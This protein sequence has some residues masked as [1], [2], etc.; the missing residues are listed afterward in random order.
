MKKKIRAA[1]IL[2]AFSCS[3]FAQQ[4]ADT[5]IYDVKVSEFAIDGVDRTGEVTRAEYVFDYEGGSEELY[6]YG[7]NGVLL[8]HLTLDDYTI[9][10]QEYDYE[11][12]HFASVTAEKLLIPVGE[13]LKV[14]AEYDWSKDGYVYWDIYNTQTD[15][16]RIEIEFWNASMAV[17]DNDY[18]YDGYDDY[19]DDYDYDKTDSEIVE[20]LR[21]KVDGVDRTD[22]VKSAEY[23]YSYSSEIEELYLYDGDGVLIERISI[24]DYELENSNDDYEE[25]YFYEVDVEKLQLTEREELEVYA[26]YDWSKEYV[27]WEIYDAGTGRTRIEVTFW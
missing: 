22:D 14:Y 20:V 24:S 6:V 5:E 13:K 16:T 4:N 15:T 1:F 23:H 7:E 3:L 26:E 11:E 17:A 27:S 18:G 9:D 19:D 12:L 8:E 25:L 10:Y 2:L 21:F